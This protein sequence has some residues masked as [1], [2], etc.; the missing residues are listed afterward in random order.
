[1]FTSL[2]NKLIFFVID[3]YTEHILVS[4]A[5]FVKKKKTKLKEFGISVQYSTVLLVDAFNQN[6]L[7]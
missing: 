1:M 5:L 2:L 4:F 6:F 7:L 3:K